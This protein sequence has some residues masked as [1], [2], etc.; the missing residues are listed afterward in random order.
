MQ[1]TSRIQQH[2]RG[3]S[4]LLCPQSK[5]LRIHE[6]STRPDVRRVYLRANPYSPKRQLDDHQRANHNTYS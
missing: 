5:P 3:E 1:S 4:Y 2:S 6:D